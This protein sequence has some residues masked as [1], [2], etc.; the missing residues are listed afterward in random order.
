[1]NYVF[2]DSKEDLKTR[3]CQIN[4]VKEEELDVSSFHVDHDMPVLK[5]FREKLLSFRDLKFFIVGDYDCDGICSTL[6]MK[7]L[8]DDLGIASN[9]YIPSR[10]KEGYGISKKIVDTAKEHGFDAVLCVDNGI[11]ADEQLRYASSLGLKTFVID[12][13]EYLDPPFA[14]VWM[15][16]S[17]FEEK[18]DDM[19]ASGLCCLLSNSIRADELTTV[20]GGLGTLADMVKVL[21][22]N[23]YL[24]KEMLKIINEKTIFPI[25]YLSKQKQF[26]F[27]TLSFDVIPKINAVSRLDEMMNVN[28]VVRYLIDNSPGCMKYL[29]K[30]EEINTVR[31]DL[32]RQMSALATR[33]ADLNRDVIVVRSDRFLEGICGLIA[34]RL[35]FE[36]DKPVIVL[37]EKD[38]MLK[39][40]GRSPKGSDLHSYLKVKEDLYETFGGHA[41]AVGI[42]MKEEAYAQFMEYIA[43]CAMER[44]PQSRDV[45]CFKKDEI[46]FDMLEQLNELKPFGNGFEEP[47]FSIEDPSYLRKFLVSSSYPK[48]VLNDQLEAIS[49]NPRH[50][51]KSFERMIGHLKRDSYRPDRLSFVIEDLL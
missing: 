47:L 36:Y 32:S 5:D 28:Y 1:M 29:N 44:Q 30:I 8:F 22:Y 50:G 14:D 11:V 24:M 26:D 6:I 17:L 23:R 10:F 33:I 18:Y 19:C 21:G 48:F 37:A 27:E 40:S 43:S 7:K 9:Y 41:Q 39:G 20:Y 25:S 31:K 12:H 51:D 13:H 2:H 49:F 16:P 38:G 4:Q 46:G 15:H 3:V 42:S 34:N 45:L 35:M